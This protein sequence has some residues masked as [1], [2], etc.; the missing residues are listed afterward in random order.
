M[1]NAWTCRVRGFKHNLDPYH[2]L[3]VYAGAHRLHWLGKDLL[4]R[5]GKR[6]EQK[7]SHFDAARR[8][9]RSSFSVTDLPRPIRRRHQ[10]EWTG[11]CQ[12]REP[13]CSIRMK[14]LIFIVH[15]I[16]ATPAFLD[17]SNALNVPPT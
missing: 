1:H 10:K 5:P 11:K 6:P 4:S 12:I 15:L 14:L 17:A 8:S 9:P 13:S 2:E 3:A 7:E 16:V